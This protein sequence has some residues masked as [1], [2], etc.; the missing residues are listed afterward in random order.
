M[1]GNKSGE[2]MDEVG[3]ALAEIVEALQAR[4][5]SSEEISAAL[6]DIVEVM[7]KPKTSG[8]SAKIAEA[9]KGL[10]IPAPRVSVNVN[11]TPVTVSAP[12]VTVSPAEVN[13]S[14]TPITIS[15]SEIRVIERASPSDY[16]LS[17]KYDDQHR[18]TEAIISRIKK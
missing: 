7:E 1:K 9:I 10:Q 15:P 17:V 4:K 3:A 8:S 11:P 2:F 16:K 5:T 13:V 12:N 14:P 18:I 6:S